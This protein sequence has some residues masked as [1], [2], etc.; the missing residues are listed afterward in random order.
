MKKLSLYVFTILFLAACQKEVIRPL[1]PCISPLTETQQT[2]PT[3]NV[4]GEQPNPNSVSSTN[5]D[6]TSGTST[7]LSDT[8]GGGI[9]DPLHKRDQRD[10]KS[11]RND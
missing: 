4:G 6:P 7:T 2:T 8:I 1:E 9:T 5:N 3:G 11:P 10:N